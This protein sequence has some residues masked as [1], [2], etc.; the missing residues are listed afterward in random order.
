MGVSPKGFDLL[1]EAAYLEFKQHCKG[2]KALNENMRFRDL[3]KLYFAEYAP[4][5]LKEVTAYNYEIAV[6]VH[7]NP[8]FGNCKLKDL[9]TGKISE[10]LT[11]LEVKALHHGK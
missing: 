6:R 2:E 10:F 8:V 3:A 1:A 7:I 5:K 9:I 11:S 4:H